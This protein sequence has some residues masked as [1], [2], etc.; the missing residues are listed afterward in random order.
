MASL[1]LEVTE[2]F[3]FRSPDDWPRWK[4]RFQ[5]FR[6]ASGLADEGEER[7]ISTIILPWRRSR[8]RAGVNQYH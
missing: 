5:Q 1:H 7:Q 6:L 2:N 8:I 4:K 3:D